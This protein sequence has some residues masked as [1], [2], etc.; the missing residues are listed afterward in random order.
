MIKLYG[1]PISTYCAKVR[2]ALRHKQLRFS[3]SAPPGGYGSPEYCAIVP[4][5]TIPGFVDGAV[6]LSES[7]AI[8]EYLDEQYPEPG[9]LPGD[10]LSRAQVR[11]L[12][13]MHDCWVEPQVRALFP[14]VTPAGRDETFV[15][16]RVQQFWLRLGRFA[17]AA[18]LSPFS[19]GSQFTMADCAW[20]TTLIQAELIFTA[21][22][23]PFELPEP[24][25]QW[26]D[27]LANVE[28]VRPELTACADS[29]RAWLEQRLSA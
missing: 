13:R 21:L 17:E 1:F 3:E 7:E 6:V 15:A 2:V 28:A 4:M 22:G 27:R 10:A 26:R 5:G 18:S 8:V 25:Q 20:S 19:A 16:Q 29:M 9:L 23:H 12:S 24:L 14:H 11:A